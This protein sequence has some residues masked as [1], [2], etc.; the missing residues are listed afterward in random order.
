MNIALIAHDNRKELMLRICTAYR[1][2]LARHS[3]CATGATGGYISEQT[4]LDVKPF[5]MGGYGGREQIGIRLA[6]N[7][8]DLALVFHDPDDAGYEEAISYIAKRCDANQIPFATNAATAE[9]L[10]LALDHGDLNWREIVNPKRSRA[11]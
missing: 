9:A 10:I 8:I 11:T 2:I 6:Y 3:L 7:E 5:M 1:G 4:G